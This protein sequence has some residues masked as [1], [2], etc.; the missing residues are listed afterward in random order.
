MR[1]ETFHLERRAELGHR[2]WVGRSR[3]T[4][5]P[6]SGIGGLALRK[7]LG[8][9]ASWMGGR[10]AEAKGSEAV[11]S[12]RSRLSLEGKWGQGA[13]RRSKKLR[14]EAIRGSSPTVAHCTKV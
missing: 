2:K 1:S 9:S 14:G 12:P 13:G 4:Q 8:A 5:G 3:R 11:D 6:L 7:G 10:A